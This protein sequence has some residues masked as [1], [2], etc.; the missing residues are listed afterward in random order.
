MVVWP[1]FKGANVLVVSASS[2]VGTTVIT[3]VLDSDNITPLYSYV[4]ITVDAGHAANL[5][6]NFAAHLEWANSGHSGREVFVYDVVRSPIGSLVSL[7]LLRGKRPGIVPILTRIGQ[8]LSPP[9]STALTPEEVA[10]V[11]AAEARVE[12]Q[13]RL[14]L[15]ARQLKSNA[16]GFNEPI[17]RFSLI[18]DRDRLCRVE[19]SLTL[20]LA[21]ESVAK[22]PLKGTD[23]DSAQARAWRDSYEKA[24]KAMGN[25]TV[26]EDQDG[27]ADTDLESPSMGI[28]NTTRGRV[29]G[30][31]FNRGKVGVE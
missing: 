13:D 17:G 25:L 12:L 7:N 15:G 2:S 28:V 24:W 18:L 6:E 29:R 26:D 16:K 20:A 4:T 3:D 10:G 21:Y 1:K 27:V 11:F 14:R 23:D 9:P 5:G 19:T 30:A 31:G 8:M 22:D